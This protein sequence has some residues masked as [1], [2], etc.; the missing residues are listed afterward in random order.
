MALPSQESIE[1]AAQL[2]CLPENGHRTMDE[3]FALSIAAA[4]D[5]LLKR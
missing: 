1:W 3:K 5:K 4:L 2:W